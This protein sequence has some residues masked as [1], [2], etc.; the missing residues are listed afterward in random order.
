MC[1][2]IWG[3]SPWRATSNVRKRHDRRQRT[4]RKS[5]V[6]TAKTRE[7]IVKAAGAEFAAYGISEAALARVMAAAGLSH[8]GFYRHFASKDLF[9]LQ[10]FSQSLLLLVSTIALLFNSKQRIHAHT[11][12]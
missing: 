9:I 12:N 3:K 11:H 10:A 1:P 4:M 7:R 2:T 8:G 5:K 6:E